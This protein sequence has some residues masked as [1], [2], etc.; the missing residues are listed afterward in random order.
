[1]KCFDPLIKNES[2]KKIFKRILVKIFNLDF[3]RSIIDDFRSIIDES[4]NVI[5]DCKWRSKL[6]HPSLM[7]LEASFMIIIFL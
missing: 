5:D 3:S 7:T 6:W 2:E 1:M 4:R